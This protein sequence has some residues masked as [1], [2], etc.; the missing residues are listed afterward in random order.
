MGRSVHVVQHTSIGMFWV[1]GWL[2]S[3]GFLKLSFS[4][5]LIALALW[6][7]YLG[8]HFAGPVPAMG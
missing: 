5:G 6:P 7:Y 8:T 4:H 1:V 2:F 3:I